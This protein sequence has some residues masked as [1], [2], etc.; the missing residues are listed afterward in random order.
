M[1]MASYVTEM[2]VVLVLF[3]LRMTRSSERF[4]KRKDSRQEQ[5]QLAGAGFQCGTRI[6][7]VCFLLLPPAYC[8]L[9]TAYCLLPTAYCSCRLPTAYCLLLTAPAACLL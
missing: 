4:A 3:A 6:L 1:Q 7:P 2:F 5:A 9:L 8:L